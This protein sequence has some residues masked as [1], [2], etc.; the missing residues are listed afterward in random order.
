MAVKL[1][2]ALNCLNPVERKMIKVC[3]RKEVVL[4]EDEEA[5][6][7][8]FWPERLETHEIM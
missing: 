4:G 7:R 8:V 1:W 6:P 3:G 5:M 2:A